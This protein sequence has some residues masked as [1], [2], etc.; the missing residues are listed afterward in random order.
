MEQP[1][2]IA[3]MDGPEWSDGDGRPDEYTVELAARAV[4]V[5]CVSA[6]PS[7]PR[8]LNCGWPHPCATH[9][10]GYE[11]LVAAGWG[12]AAIGALD[13]RTGAWS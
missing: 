1:V 10:W 12:A 7:G 4:R 13:E 3:T 2:G 11:A 8:C 9:Q 5:H 6:T